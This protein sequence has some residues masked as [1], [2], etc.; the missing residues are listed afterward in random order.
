MQ[1]RVSDDERLAEYLGGRS[2][3]TPLKRLDHLA[4]LPPTWS[5]PAASG[6]K[7]SVCRPSVRSSRQPSSCASFGSAT[8]CSSCSGRPRRTVRSASATVGLNSMC[9]FEVEDLDVAVAH[10]RAAA[11]FA[12]PGPRLGTLPG[13]RVTTVPGP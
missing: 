11:G 5:A 8:P 3:G 7:S 10:V 12:V 6:T 2:H 4:A 9:S 13:T 1:P